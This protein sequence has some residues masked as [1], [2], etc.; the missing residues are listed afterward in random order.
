MKIGADERILFSVSIVNQIRRK[1]ND[2]KR[3]KRERDPHDALCVTSATN[4]VKDDCSSGL[5]INWATSLSRVHCVCTCVYT[6]VYVCVYVCVSISHLHKKKV[7]RLTCLRHADQRGK[8]VIHLSTQYTVRDPHKS[9]V[10]QISPAAH[11]S[12]AADSF[13]F[14]SVQLVSFYHPTATRFFLFFFFSVFSVCPTFFLL[15]MLI[16]K[17]NTEAS[18]REIVW[19][20]SICTNGA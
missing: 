8:T 19:P 5:R 10:K 9:V 2:E 7:I 11:F 14:I 20:C 12:L 13:C 18:W 15:Q 1:V 16:P 17:R 6:C 3:S 4:N